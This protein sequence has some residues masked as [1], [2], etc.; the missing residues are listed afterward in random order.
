MRVVT[1]PEP[2]HPLGST[3]IFLGGSIELGKA[4]EWQLDVIEC[5]KDKDI[6][7][8]NPR[9]KDWDSTWEQSINNPKFNEQVD[10]EGE[11]KS[12]LQTIYEDGKFFNQTTLTQIR[13]RLEN[14]K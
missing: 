9:R 3:N 7:I 1:A 11:E 2:I 14:G 5:L 8:F 12:L 13:E 6:T 10:W 4:L